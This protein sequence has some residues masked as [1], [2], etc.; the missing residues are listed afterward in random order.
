MNINENKNDAFNFNFE[1]DDTSANKTRVIFKKQ[2]FYVALLSLLA[3]IGLTAL[4]AINWGE[5]DVPNEQAA[6]PSPQITQQA[7][8]TPVPTPELTPE[9]DDKQVSATPSF[10]L[11]LPVKNGR[12]VKSASL[13]K[14]VYNQTLNQWATHN[15]TDIKADAG[16]E[17]IAARAGTVEA[18]RKDDIVGY[19]I[20]ISLSDGKKTVYAGAKPLDSISE[21]SK[22]NEGDTIGTLE[23]P[24]FEKHLEAH[25]HFEL[26]DGSAYLDPEK[27][28]K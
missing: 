14:L 3:V 2:G 4:L 27:Y 10:T 6:A 7:Q 5:K 1:D 26:R 13:D 9:P 24:I 20:V 8:I 12:I 28:I 18:I 15:G 22:V 21:G 23:T 17:V 25:L 19:T 11:T 16:S